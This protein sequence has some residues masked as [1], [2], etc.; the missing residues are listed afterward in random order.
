M[1]IKHQ[2]R[3]CPTFLHPLYQVSPRRIL[4]L[5]GGENQHVLIMM[6]LHD[7]FTMIPV[8]VDH[9]SLFMVSFIIEFVC[10]YCF[11]FVA[12]GL[13]TFIQTFFLLAPIMV[14]H[15]NLT[16][17]FT[18]CESETTTYFLIYLHGAIHVCVCVY[19][20]SCLQEHGEHIK[21]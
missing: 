14:H 7:G 10:I 11:F 1:Y 9:A 6:T 5:P 8:A 19:H 17:C 3:C 18:W 15:S 21:S 16:I 20:K 2:S 13:V 4:I 12:S